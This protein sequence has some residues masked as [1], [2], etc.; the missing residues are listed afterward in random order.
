MFGT[1]FSA[2]NATCDAARRP[3]VSFQQTGRRFDAESLEELE[4]LLSS[5]EGGMW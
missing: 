5:F 3:I 4:R 2:D 1:T